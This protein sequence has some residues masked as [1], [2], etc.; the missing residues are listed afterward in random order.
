MISEERERA[1]DDLGRSYVVIQDVEAV[2]TALTDAEFRTIETNVA[3][4]CAER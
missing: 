1:S 3:P 4:Y 2:A